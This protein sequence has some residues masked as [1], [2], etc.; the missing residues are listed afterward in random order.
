MRVATFSIGGE[1]RVGL[2]DLDSGTVAPFD[3]PVERGSGGR[4]GPDRAQRRRRCRARCRP[5]RFDRVDARGA[6]PA[7]A[8]Q[9][10]LRRQELSRARPRVRQKRLRFQRRQGRRARSTRS[11]SRRCR[12]PSSPTG[13]E[14]LIDQAVSAAIDYEAELAVIIGKAGPR[15]PARK[16]LRPRLGLHDRQRRH[17]ARPAGPLQPVADRQIAG[18]VLPDGPLGG[19]QGRDRRRRHRLSAASSTA[20]SARIRTPAC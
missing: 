15:H 7:A 18:H 20:T 11:S 1:R 6:D 2:V 14:V 19:D 3:L 4:A 10:L 13:A 16:R 9:H 12:R 17:G 5:S 8:P